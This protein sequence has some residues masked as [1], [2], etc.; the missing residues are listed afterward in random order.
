MAFRVLTLAGFKPDPH[1]LYQFERDEYFICYPFERD[2][3]TSTNIHMVEA[4]KGVDDARTMKAA[5]W[6]RSAQ[7]D[8]G[9]WMDKWHAS[10]YYPTGHAVIALCGVDDP[11]AK[12][13]VE[14]IL[15]TQQ[16]CGC[17]GFYD[18]PSAEETAYCLQALCVYDR[19]V[20]PVER[21]I[22]ARGREGLLALGNESPSLWIG[23]CLYTPVHV[24]K[25][26]VCSALALTREE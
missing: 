5:R 13:A 21:D 1:P 23:K 25:S 19:T 18:S 10:P 12:S 22:L 9:Y 24:V 7:L 2:P 15:E 8:G 20:E 11:L 14:W 4:L 3:S 16:P 17:W 6:L 26:A